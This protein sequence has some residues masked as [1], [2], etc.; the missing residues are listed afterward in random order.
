[1]NRKLLIVLFAVFWVALA[2]GQINKVLPQKG[3]EGMPVKIDTTSISEVIGIYGEDFRI[4]ENPTYTRYFYK[5]LGI[6]FQFE[7]YDKNQIVRSI[8]LESPFEA[9]LENGIRLNE[10]T[11][12]DVWL[13]Y[14]NKGCFTSAKEARRP[15]EGITFYIHK[16]PK[17]RGYNAK[18]KIFKFEIHNKGEF[19]IPSRVN[20]EFDD[21]P[22]D[23]KMDELISILE[24]DTIN[25]NELDTFL[26]KENEEKGKNSKLY[27]LE[28]RLVFERQLESG[29]T[30]QKFELDPWS[31]TY[32][33]NILKKGSSLIYLR[34]ERRGRDAE[35]IFERDRTA[36][37][38]E[39]KGR[40]KEYS[41]FIFGSA[42]GFAGTAPA[43]CSRMYN[44]ANEG[45]YTELAKWLHS[46]N[47]ELA[48][49][50]YIG[51]YIMKKEGNTIQTK[52]LER[53]K[54]L[55]D[56]EV[57]LRICLGCLYGGT[58]TT[59]EALSKKRLKDF[60]Y[61]FRARY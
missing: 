60:Y 56:S 32:G 30:Q 61:S 5:D 53:M 57:K 24:K 22:F 37:F 59:K 26:K 27:S 54:Q 17:Q 20:Y 52:E 40:Y 23:R 1:M 4:N 47:P 44:W 45:N 31:K 21:D 10:S 35:V 9:E 3:I 2:Q 28:S 58:E 12:E 14:N 11:M 15:E 48:A 51:L 8:Y 13:A 55:K 16:K 33:L 50:G 38:E 39:L 46:I 7:T 19:G 29:I 25:F 41:V 6:T 43:G 49:Y 42:C 18:N 36:N 34:L